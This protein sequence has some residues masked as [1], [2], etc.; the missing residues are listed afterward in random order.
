MESQH[1][2]G[3]PGFY[4]STVANLKMRLLLVLVPSLVGRSKHT[5]L[6][7]Q[8]RKRRALVRRVE[9]GSSIPSCWQV[10]VPVLTTTV[11]EVPVC[12]TGGSAFCC[13]KSKSVQIITGYALPVYVSHWPG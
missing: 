10:P 8:R 9:Y 12:L 5:W 11:V 7:I 3:G 2:A 1:S 13:Q 4:C 6:G